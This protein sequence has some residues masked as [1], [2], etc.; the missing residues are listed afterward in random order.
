M[1]T[2]GTYISYKN[3]VDPIRPHVTTLLNILEVFLLPRRLSQVQ[4]SSHNDDMV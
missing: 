1:K 3:K 2:R 4:L